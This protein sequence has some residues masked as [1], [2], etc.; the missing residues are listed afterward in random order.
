MYKAM[1][2]F[3]AKEKGNKNNNE[4]RKLTLDAE[5]TR[6][7]IDSAL[8]VHRRLHS[9][10]NNTVDTLQV[11]LLRSRAN[12][13]Q[14]M[15]GITQEI[16]HMETLDQHLHELRKHLVK[17]RK[18]L[19]GL[20]T[21]KCLETDARE[22]ERRSKESRQRAS[23]LNQH[24]QT[25]LLTQN[26]HLDIKDKRRQLRTAHATPQRRKP[27]NAVAIRERL[28]SQTVAWN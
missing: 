19:G 24:L 14:L 18:K 13:A 22:L 27:I 28:T 12:N 8:H 11:K 7:K 10:I 17:C 6:L 4:V 5:V 20:N 16:Q 9:H 1:A 25:V 23:K 15:A 2:D 26:V 21:E 3:L